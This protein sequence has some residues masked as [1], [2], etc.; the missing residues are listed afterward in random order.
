MNFGNDCTNMYFSSTSWPKAGGRHSRRA[1][2]NMKLD[3]NALRYLTK[4]DFRV[5]TAVEM[6]QKNVGRTR[7]EGA[8]FAVLTC[9]RPRCAHAARD[10]A[11]LASRHDCGTEVSRACRPCGT[12]AAELRSVFDV[13]ADTVAHSNV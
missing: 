1:Y 6:G 11:F 10:C 3:T 13:H 8:S 2:S 4:E 5:L 12:R 7:A 9:A